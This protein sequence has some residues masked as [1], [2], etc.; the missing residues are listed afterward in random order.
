MMKFN[1][2]LDISGLLKKKS[3]FLFGPRATGKTT[4][5]YDQLR[6]DACVIDLLKSDYVLRLSS[7][8]SELEAVIERNKKTFVVIDEIQKIPLLLDE[9]QRL[10][11]TKKYRFLLTGSSARKLKAGRSNLLA[12]RAWNAELFPLTSWEIGIENMNL[13]KYF[14]HGGL[15]AIY[16]SSDPKE[17][18]RAYIRNYLYEE[19]QAEGIVRKIPAFS[20]FLETAA[21]TNGQLLNYAQIASDSEV[22]APTVREYYQILVDTLIGFMVE[23]WTKSKK[24]KA[25]STAKFYFFDCGVVHALQ[26]KWNISEQSVDFGN[27]LEHFIAMEL[28]SYLHYSRIFEELKFWR[29]TSQFE[30]DFVIADQMAIEVK[31]K[32]K[33]S[34]RDLKNIKALQEENIF[35]KYFLV[36]Q[37]PIEAVRNRVTCVPWQTFL[38]DLWSGNI[39]K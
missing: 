24:R 10:I 22:P 38:K 12:G 17:E 28:R 7:R 35:K 14:L 19:I 32:K 9:I 34:D 6:H 33:V 39:I 18:L 20:R 21:L 23:P 11:E 2:C 36:S 29:S 15:P 1:R 31:A 30:V 8:P 37:D 27:A 25:I 13:K 4:L 5:I 26:Q 16:L 3:I